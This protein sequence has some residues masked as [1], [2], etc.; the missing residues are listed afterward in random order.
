MQNRPNIRILHIA[1]LFLLSAG[2]LLP[3]A[4]YATPLQYDLIAIRDK[5][6]GSFEKISNIMTV[7]ITAK[8]EDIPAFSTMAENMKTASR[9]TIAVMREY[10]ELA[11]KHGVANDK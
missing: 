11:E 6:A 5:M 7:G 2:C 4:A 3:H 8:P 10:A 9:E 1:L